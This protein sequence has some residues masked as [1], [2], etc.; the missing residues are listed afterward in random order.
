MPSSIV[1]PNDGDE[2]PC[3]D[4]KRSEGGIPKNADGKNQASE[5]QADAEQKT[6]VVQEGKHVQNEKAVDSIHRTGRSHGA[7]DRNVQNREVLYQNE[8]NEDDFSW[9]ISS[10]GCKS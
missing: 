3:E 1:W 7:E 2:R 5:V 9:S 8:N 4:P 6:P 10:T